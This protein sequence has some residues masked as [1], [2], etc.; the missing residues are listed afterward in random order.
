ML[1]FF[2]LVVDLGRLW[3]ACG[4]VQ[5][6]LDAAALAGANTVSVQLEVDRYG[7]VYSQQFV[8]DPY[9]ADADARSTLEANISHAGATVTNVSVTINGTK[10]S[11]A[12]TFDVPMSLLAAW[13]SAPP[14]VTLT[15]S[16]SADCTVLL[17]P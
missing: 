9:R 4:E 12:A 16:A 8:T 5:K 6:A 11:V 15:R 7:T 13:A 10:V 17:N 2:A 1:V 3:V 14:R